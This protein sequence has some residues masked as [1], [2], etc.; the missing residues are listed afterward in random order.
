MF[1]GVMPDHKHP[2]AYVRQTTDEI[3]GRR[4]EGGQHPN[5]S[6]NDAHEK[7]GFCFFRHREKEI[8]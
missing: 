5:Q 3:T 4:Y 1:V 8:S 2:R 7:N 6:G